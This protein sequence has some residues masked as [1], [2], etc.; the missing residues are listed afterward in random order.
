MKAVLK[1]TAIL[2]FFLLVW[3]VI[4]V[5][6]MPLQFVTEKLDSSHALV[7]NRLSGT[8]WKGSAN[9]LFKDKISFVADLSWRWCPVWP[10]KF[11]AACLD[12]ST[13]DF[14]FAG[15]LGYT[16]F[17]GEIFAIDSIGDF[18][19]HLHT[20]GNTKLPGL[21]SGTGVVNIKRL[22]LDAE[23]MLPNYAEGKGELKNL[24][25]MENPLGD[26]RFS[27]QTDDSGIV[28]VLCK[29]GGDD[30]NIDGSLLFNSA[31]KSYQ[32]DAE[33]GTENPQFFSLLKPFG[34]AT[35]G[36]RVKLSRRGKLRT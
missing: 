20:I 28:T 33:I 31:E 10:Q 36:N 12:L 32:I 26:F 15:T 6:T 30:F 35:G 9:F 24:V 29:G 22:E 13:P 21:V 25:A 14:N 19:L 11:L 4:F 23:S 16:P 5:S 8:I 2:L 3:G 1:K 17:G 27:S 34:P 7:V 18:S